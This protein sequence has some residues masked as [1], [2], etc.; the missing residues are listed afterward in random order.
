MALH[1]A[2]IGAV[3]DVRYAPGNPVVEQYFGRYSDE[4]R[5]NAETYGYDLAGDLYR[6]HITIT[7][8]MSLPDP[9]VLPRSSQDLSFAIRGIG[10]FVADDQG[11]A[12]NL[13][14]AFDLS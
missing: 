4:Q 10:L 7:R 2:A 14:A 11:A 1:H 8:F 5:E 9:T 3:Q 12:R 6:P 13:V